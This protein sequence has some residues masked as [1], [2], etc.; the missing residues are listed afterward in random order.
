MESSYQKL[1]RK[2]EEQ[3]LAYKKLRSDFKKYY[4]NDFQTKTMY[5]LQFKMEDDFE[6]LIW[7]GK[8]NG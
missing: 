3:E 1:K 6:Q 2:I 5:D 4:N 7:G 8:S